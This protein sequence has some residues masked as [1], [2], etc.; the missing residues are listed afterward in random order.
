V[1]E[2]PMG[3]AVFWT[4]LGLAAAPSPE[5]APAPAETAERTLHPAAPDPAIAVRTSP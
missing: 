4:M 2:G 1:L 5:P 3:A